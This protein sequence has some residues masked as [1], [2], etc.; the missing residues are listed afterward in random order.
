MLAKCEDD[1]LTIDTWLMSCRV[2][3]RGV[4]TLLHNYL[5]CRAQQRGIRRI[6][7]EYI[8]TAKNALVKDHYA[9]LGFSP[10]GE[11]ADRSLWEFAIDDGWRPQVTQIAVED[12]FPQE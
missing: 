6:R 2:L 4:E 10:V 11:A 8:P 9:G 12:C 3:K 5:C 7:G 1:V